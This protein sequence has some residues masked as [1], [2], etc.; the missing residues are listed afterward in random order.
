MINSVLTKHCDIA[1][2]NVNANFRVT[3]KHVFELLQDI[4]T[5]QADI[6]GFGWTAMRDVNKVWVLSKMCV[7][8]DRHIG[9]GESIQ[10][11]TWPTQPNRFFA[12]R[13]FVAKDKEGN[14]VFG[15]ISKWCLVDLTTHSITNPNFVQPMFLG[16]YQPSACAVSDNV[17]K[18]VFDETYTH[19]YDKVVRWSDLDMNLH[20]NNTNYLNY[21]KD[22]AS[23][24]LV[25]SNVKRV[26]V[27]YHCE[28]KIGDTLSIYSKEQDNVLKVIGKIQDKMCFTVS[29]VFC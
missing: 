24:N 9:L 13:E 8:F 6:L 28:A 19:Q 2:S 10:L 11:S 21:A 14:R 26:E 25:E 20:V 18:L 3:L 27:V 5:E 22:C 12:N 15:A 29:V 4:A 16:E 7:D 23:Q 1:V 17:E